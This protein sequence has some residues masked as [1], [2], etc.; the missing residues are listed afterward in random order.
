MSTHG[1]AV[2]KIYIDKQTP[3]VFQAM[4]E[5]SRAARKAASE[6]GL[7]RILVELVELRISQV[8]RCAYCLDRHTKAALKA[9]ESAQRLAVLAAWRGTEVFS[10]AERAALA[11]AEATTDL[12]DAKARDDAYEAARGALTEHQISAVIWLAIAIN[13]LNRVSVMSEHPVRSD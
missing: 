4:R 2:P 12:A 3:E 11:L 10:P 5:T 8:N 13:A 9:G 1:S 7:D 6:A